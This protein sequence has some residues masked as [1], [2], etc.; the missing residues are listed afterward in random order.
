M[1]DLTDLTSWVGANVYT[2]IWADII[3][4]WIDRFE[5]GSSVHFII[6]EVGGDTL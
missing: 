4:V 1:F 3:T 5:I 2:N 6:N